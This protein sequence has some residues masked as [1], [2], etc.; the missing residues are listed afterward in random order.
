MTSWSEAITNGNTPP[1]GALLKAGDEL[2]SGNETLTFQQYTKA[3]LPLDGWVFWVKNPTPTTFVAKGSFHVAVETQQLEDQTLSINELI[4]TSE[5]MINQ[6]NSINSQ[7]M[8]IADLGHIK[9]AFN[10]M[11]KHYRQADLWHYIGNAI[12]PN[13]RINIIDD[14]ASLDLDN[15]IVSNSLPIW[16][17]LNNYTPTL[18]SYGFG[19]S[20]QLYPSFLVPENIGA[21]YG[22]VHVESGE[23][24][25]ISAAPFL[26]QNSSHFQLCSDKV[27]IVLWGI[28]NDQA[29]TFIDCVLQFSR[30]Y[31]YIGIMNQIPVVRD[32]RHEKEAQSEVMII[33]QKKEI[34]FEVSYY[35]T[36]VRDIARQVITNF[37]N[38]FMPRHII[39]NPVAPP[40][41]IID[42]DPVLSV[43]WST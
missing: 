11:K 14:P 3:I 30:D 41:P 9:F 22:S 32:V 16:L 18:P 10:S 4:F 20:I 28:R 43:P 5:V 15:V 12:Y 34:H 7:T 19:N 42:S 13:Q 2:L 35:Q 6:L 26:D 8:W 17:Y 21:P 33:S 36:S 23:T 31:D 24:F 29:Q 37:V 38:T 39:H 25:G 1:L 40:Y 27:K